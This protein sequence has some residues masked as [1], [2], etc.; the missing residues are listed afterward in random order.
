MLLLNIALFALRYVHIFRQESRKVISSLPSSFHSST[1]PELFIL[2][3]SQSPNNA[4]P[5]TLAQS[6]SS[7]FSSSGSGT[8]TATYTILPSTTNGAMPMTTSA[9]S[10]Y[11]RRHGGD[12]CPT[13]TKTVERPARMC[14]DEGHPGSVCVPALW[15][16]T[17]TSTFTVGCGCPAHTPTKTTSECNTAC[18][19]KTHWLYSTMSG[20]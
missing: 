20:C 2:I 4:L 1:Q 15:E 9:T 12:G 19:E 3:H 13:I 6:S 17:K 11:H 14:V 5:T 16:G 8:A 10:T 7:M 18:I